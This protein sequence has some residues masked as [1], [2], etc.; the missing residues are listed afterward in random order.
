MFQVNGVCRFYDCCAAERSLVLL[1]SDYKSEHRALGFSRLDPRRGFGHQR[2]IGPV[3]LGVAPLQIFFHLGIGTS[4]EVGQI[5]GYLHRTPCRRKQVQLDHLAPA[6]NTRGH[7]V[8]RRIYRFEYSAAGVERRFGRAIV[9]GK[10]LEQVQL[11]TDNGT[12]I[13][14]Y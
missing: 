1:V 8:W 6:R 9:R 14:Q 5:L 12:T 10:V 2:I 11:D 7:L 3:M 13:E 4:P